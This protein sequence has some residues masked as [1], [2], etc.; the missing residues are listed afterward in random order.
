MSKIIF[1]V[2][3]E[4]NPEKRD[5]YLSSIVELKS[6]LKIDG[7]ESYSV[8]EVKGKSNN[9]EEIF[10]FTSKEAYDNYDDGENE[11]TNILISKIEEL[12]IR[13]T[14]KYNTLVEVA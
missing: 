6:L 14:T 10:V 5:D 7:I 11:R 2:Q 9:F 13:N 8:Y 1:T 3:Y 4:I 12:K